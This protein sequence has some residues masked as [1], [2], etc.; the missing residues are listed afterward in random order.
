LDQ[1]KI[2]QE[3]QDITASNRWESDNL[4]EDYLPGAY[5]I[6]GVEYI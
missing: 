5:D 2:Y 1:L 6:K 4:A 3:A